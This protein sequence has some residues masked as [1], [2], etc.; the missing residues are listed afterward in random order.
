MRLCSIYVHTYIQTYIIDVRRTTL[1][2]VKLCDNFRA[3]VST[4]TPCFDRYLQPIKPLVDIVTQLDH[5]RV[6]PVG[7]QC[8]LE[9]I[10]P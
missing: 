4:V 8:V 1:T 2:I 5:R 7:C 10:H 9:A 6:A 3:L